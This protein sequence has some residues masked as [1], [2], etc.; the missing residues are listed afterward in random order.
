[1]WRS[2]RFPPLRPTLQQLL[3][4]LMTTRLR[5]VPIVLGGCALLPELPSLS[6]STHKSTRAATITVLVCSYLW[7]QQPALACYLLQPCLQS[8]HQDW[9]VVP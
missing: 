6:K 4:S 5:W 2:Y 7:T 8:L 3:F 1:M 9:V